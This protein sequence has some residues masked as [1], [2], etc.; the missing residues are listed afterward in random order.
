MNNSL[1]FLIGLGLGLGVAAGLRPF[2][3]ALLAGGL[4]ALNALGIDFAPG[5]FSFLQEGWWLIIAVVCFVIS[6]AIQMQMGSERFDSGAA[7]AALS[8][9]GVGV[10]ALLFAGTLSAHGDLAWPGLVGGA[11]VAAMAQASVRPI[12]LRAR[13]RLPDRNSKEA[14]TLYLDGAAVLVA[15]LACL[16]HPLGYVAVLLFAW[17]LL[18]GRRRDGRRYAGLR[19]LGG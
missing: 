19:I 4:A 18:A 13:R 1:I 16:L 5:A 12:V 8:G 15:V 7:A 2:L 9:I 17:L 11:L 6:Y 14:L 10:G 3:P